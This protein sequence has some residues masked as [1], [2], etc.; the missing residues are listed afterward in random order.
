MRAGAETGT[1]DPAR[2]LRA[3]LTR[4]EEEDAYRCINCGDEFEKDHH[5]CPSCGRPYVAEME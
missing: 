1:M 4:D 5:D 2:L 3:L